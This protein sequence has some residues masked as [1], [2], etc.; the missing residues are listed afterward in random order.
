[1]CL[2]MR[3]R[4]SVHTEF[5]LGWQSG[6]DLNELVLRERIDEVEVGLELVW[7]VVPVALLGRA[8]C[9]R[10]CLKSDSQK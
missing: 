2:A 5:V 4:T 8:M 7:R 10:F 6:S 1:M 3:R 9:R